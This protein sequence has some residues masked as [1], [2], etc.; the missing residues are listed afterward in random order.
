VYAIK[1]CG[2]TA[3]NIGS[4]L[5]IFSSGSTEFISGAIMFSYFGDFSNNKTGMFFSRFI[6]MLLPLPGTYTE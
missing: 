6:L 5:P 1:N 4:I 3:D 2:G